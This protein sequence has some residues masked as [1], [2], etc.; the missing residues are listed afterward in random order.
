MAS[1]GAAP[2]APPRM[3]PWSK[4]SGPRLGTVSEVRSI[5]VSHRGH[6]APSDAWPRRPPCA[7]DQMQRLRV[8][9]RVPLS[10]PGLRGGRARGLPG[11]EV[12]GREMKVGPAPPCPPWSR[13]R[14]GRAELPGTGTVRSSMIHH[15]CRACQLVIRSVGTVTWPWLLQRWGLFAGAIFSFHVARG[16]GR[17]H[18]CRADPGIPHPH[19]LRSAGPGALGA[20][21]FFPK[22]RTVEH[23]LFRGLCP[24]RNSRLCPIRATLSALGAK[25][26][27]SS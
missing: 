4:F 12:S 25:I 3:L 27:G 20:R 6:R 21:L 8:C 18:E 1:W 9:R 5:R 24:P 17:P 13:H 19:V 11:A 7:A 22:L 10:A 16:A 26:G 23:L 15:P 2:R 14:A